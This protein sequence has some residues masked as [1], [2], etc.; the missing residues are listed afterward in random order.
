ML[1]RSGRFTDVSAAAGM[2]V[3]NPATG[4]PAAKTLGVAP[5]DLNGDGWMDL[6]V[7]ND[8][9]QNFV[10]ENQRN[11]TFKEVGA[12]SGIGFDSYGNTRG[13]MGMDVARFTRDGR[14]A[15]AIGNFANEMTA[16]Y[17][18]QANPML[19]TDEAIS[20]G[21]IGRAHV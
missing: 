6:V 3:R 14:L 18:A 1:F 10:F 21:K 5:V 11:G 2:Q 4:V 16:F 17:V 9:V 15:V 8:T 13:A 19:F 20:W 7:A 12:V